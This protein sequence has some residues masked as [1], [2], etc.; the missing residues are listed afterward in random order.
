[1]RRTHVTLMNG[2]RVEGKLVADQIRHSLDVQQ[3]VYTQ[4]P[5][6]NR[7]VAIN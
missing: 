5:V 4:S 3:N 6:A 7:Q 1:M 2:L